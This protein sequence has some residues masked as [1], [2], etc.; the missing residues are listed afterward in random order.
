LV[1]G[2][3]SVHADPNWQKDFTLILVAAIAKL[4]SKWRNIH[5][6]HLIS[7]HTSP[8]GIANINH[9]L[10]RNRTMTPPTD[11]SFCQTKATYKTEKYQHR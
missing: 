9:F 8:G 1:W 7:I 6:F 4:G 10:D 2:K 11:K 3:N 5:C